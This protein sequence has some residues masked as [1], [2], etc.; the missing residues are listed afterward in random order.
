[1]VAPKIRFGG[2]K[3]S[4]I[5]NTAIKSRLKAVPV[6]AENCFQ[7]QKSKAGRG[8]YATP[9]YDQTVK[10]CE[11]F[12]RHRKNDYDIVINKRETA[13]RLRYEKLNL[14]ICFRMQKVLD[15]YLTKEPISEYAEN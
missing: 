12:K 7:S 8:F 6:H 9:L 11:E 3:Y 1:M 14:Q 5:T 4:D 2:T 10:W 13:R 15:E